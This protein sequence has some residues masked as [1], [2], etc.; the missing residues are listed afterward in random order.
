MR[1]DARRIVGEIVDRLIV[2]AKERLA[3][4]IVGDPKIEEPSRRHGLRIDDALA[5]EAVY[6]GRQSD[7]PHA[8]PVELLED[9]PLD[10]A[11]LWADEK[12][13]TYARRKLDLVINK[14]QPLSRY[15]PELRGT[16]KHPNMLL[17]GLHET[18]RSGPFHKIYSEATGDESQELEWPDSHRI[19]FYRSILGVPLY[20]FP[21]INDDMQAAYQRFQSQ[22]EQA[23]PLHIDHH[24]ERLPDLDPEDRR[25]ELEAVE[26]QRRVSVVGLA[27]GLARGVIEELAMTEA[28]VHGYQL[29]VRD[30]RTLTLA[31][32]LLPAADALMALRKEMPAVY[33][34]WV[35]P[36]LADVAA[37]DDALAGELRQL[38]RSWASRAQDLELDGKSRSPEYRDLGAARTI[39]AG[40]IGD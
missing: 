10:P 29:R 6:Y 26:T 7:S 15:V 38:S 23:W 37:L 18:L 21:H 11:K 28:G 27:L 17:V 30:D 40:V 12:V 14:A 4:E 16:I 34:S 35:A 19:V 36:L 5:L 1:P 8:D 39:L 13:R 32:G 31:E 25:R 24:W 9:R 20:C 3:P 2:M 22:R 33:D